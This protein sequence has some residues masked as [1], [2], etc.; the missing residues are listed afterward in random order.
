[1]MH[2]VT[3]LSG[4][5]LSVVAARKVHRYLDLK[6]AVSTVYTFLT[7]LSKTLFKMSKMC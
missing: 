5:M 6:N 7:K 1:M 2:N 4:I 3:M